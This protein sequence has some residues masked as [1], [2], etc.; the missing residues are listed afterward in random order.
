MCHVFYAPLPHAPCT[1]AEG[2]LHVESRLNIRKHKRDLRRV[3]LM[4]QASTTPTRPTNNS[5][6]NPPQFN[7]VAGHA[8]RIR[9]TLFKA[10]QCDC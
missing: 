2:E 4:F 3:P 9:T 1:Y 10:R 8:I 7:V 6:G 5:T